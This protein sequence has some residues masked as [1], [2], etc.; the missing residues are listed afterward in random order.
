MDKLSPEEIKK[1]IPFEFDLRIQCIGDSHVSVFNGSNTPSETGFEHLDILR[2]FK[3]YRIGPYL[4]YNIG[5]G[6]H[7]GSISLHGSLSKLDPNSII[8]LSFGEIDC[9]EHLKKQSEEQNKTYEDV[10]KEC[11][12][13]YFTAIL[14]IKK[15]F[16]TIIILGP[17]P[18]SWSTESNKICKMFNEYI[19]GLC[20]ENGIYFWTFFYDIVSDD[21]GKMAE[22]YYDGIHLKS[23]CLYILKDKFI[24][25]EKGLL[26]E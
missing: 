17:Q 25:F 19:E 8:L 12:D 3:T 2:N 24:E 16:K 18:C 20:N 21:V 6:E 7:P 1:L 5:Q 11:V 15:T 14:D 26:N 4:A 10:V 9:R 23:E 13:V 22:F